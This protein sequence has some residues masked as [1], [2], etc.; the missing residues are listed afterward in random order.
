MLPFIDSA[1]SSSSASENL[2]ASRF[3]HIDVASPSQ[4]VTRKNYRHY[5]TMSLILSLDMDEEFVDACLT[6]QRQAQM[7]HS[8]ISPTNALV[9]PTAGTFP[10]K[11]SRL[12]DKYANAYTDFYGSGTPC[13]FKT[14]PAWHKREGLDA[15]GIVREPRPIYRHAIGPTWLSI[16][17]NIYQNLDSMDI[18]WT[19][20][21]PL[22]YANAGEAKPFCSFVVVIG[23][24]PYSLLYDAAVAAAEV[25]QKI[26]ADADFPN[27]DVAFVESVVTRSVATGPRL[28][29]FDP[30]L[31]DVPELRKPFTSALGLSIA[32][33][34]Y[35]HYEGTGAL[36]Y[37]VSRDDNR[38]AILTCAHV[39]RPPPAYANTGI[40]MRKNASQAREEVT[41]LGSGGYSNAVKAIMGEIGDLVRYI[42]A[43]NGVLTRLGDPVEGESG[44]ITDRRREHLELVEKATKRI[45]EAN[46]L[47]DEVTKRRTTPDQRVI[48]FVLHSEQIKV[49]VEPHNFTQDWALIELYNEKIDW[50]SFKGNQVYVGGNLS[51]PE[52]GNTLFPQPA[53]R[54]S[55]SYPPDGLLQ[56][57]GVVQAAKF[58]D[59]QHLDVHNEKSL[60]VIKNGL[61]TGT[62][63][64]RVNGLESFTRHY[65]DNGIHHTSIEDGRIVG[66]LTGG[67]GLSDGIDITYLTPYW[68]VEQQVK[69]KFPDCFLYDVVQ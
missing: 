24:K 38:V 1:S 66:L 60:L 44:R 53:D 36:Y 9:S 4:L 49:S 41:A 58:S 30:L 34:K 23:V 47:H 8:P 43:W 63:V 52:F 55:Y 19:S 14:G 59:P 69:A 31:D 13:I 21:N 15:R 3:L 54:A 62:T 7:N 28:L 68:W 11:A 56:A 27:I 26:L 57:Y 25:V 16:G 22:A 37:R 12:T 40:D 48:G 35:P 67:A 29:S 2:F 18:Q 61:T 65:E 20:I 51:I 5:I 32:T 45:K 39:A 17:K 33:L 10:K 42:E 64:G 50:Q 6:I 46:A